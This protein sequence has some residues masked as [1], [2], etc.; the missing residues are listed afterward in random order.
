MADKD[1]KAEHEITKNQQAVE[2]LETA[3]IK[4]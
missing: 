1:I 2:G 3:C 4:E